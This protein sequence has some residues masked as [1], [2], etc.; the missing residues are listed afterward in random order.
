[1]WATL[2]ELPRYH[3][4]MIVDQETTEL[5]EALR[6][7]AMSAAERSAWLENVWGRVQRNAAAF[8]VNAPEQVHTARSYTTL[9]EKNRFDEARELAFAMQ[10]SIYATQK[11]AKNP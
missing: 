6:V 9:D 7:Q 5:A 1:M 11:T 4:S 8:F 2:R 3:S 10:H